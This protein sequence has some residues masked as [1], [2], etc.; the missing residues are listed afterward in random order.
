MKALSIVASGLTSGWKC[1]KSCFPNMST[2]LLSVIWQ[3]YWMQMTDSWLPNGSS[4][5]DFCQLLLTSV[6]TEMINIVAWLGFG[7]V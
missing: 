2:S 4:E 5:V 7:R 6:M 1:V 3:F